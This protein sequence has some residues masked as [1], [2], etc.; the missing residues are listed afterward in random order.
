[1]SSLP[2]DKTYNP[3]AVE[4]KWAAHW[5]EHRLFQPR[6]TGKPESFCMVIP[7]PNV[8]GSLHIGHALNNTLQDILTRWKRMQGLQT[9]W[10]PGTD[11]AGI[12]TQNV[13]ERQL[14]EEGLSREDLGRE[15]F[16]ERVWAW[17]HQSGDTIIGQLKQ[18][19]ASC[20]WDRL[21]FTMDK[22][23]SLA[24]RKVF[25][26]LY[27]EGLIYRGERL[28][29]WCPRCL[30]ALSDIEVEHEDIKGT[31]YHIRYN[32]AEDPEAFLTVATTRPETL[33]GDTAVAV[34]PDD[35]RYQ[36]FI[37]KQIKLPLTTR[38]IPIVADPILVDREFGTGAVKITPAH[39]FNDFEA[40]ERHGLT[41]LTILDFKARM[42]A[43]GLQ[44][45]MVDQSLLA[46][47]S[48][49]SVQ[50][51]R[52][53]VIEAL[54]QQD[55]LLKEEDH[56]MALGKCYRCKTVVE[57]YLSPQWFVK[58]SPLAAP[59]ID[60]VE[61]GSIRIIPEGWK[62]NYLGWMRQIKDWCIS[63]QIWWGHQIPAWY[64]RT[65]NKDHL[66][67]PN[68][69]GEGT[70]DG[71]GMSPS[72]TINPSS[73]KRTRTNVLNVEGLIYSKIRTF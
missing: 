67:E 32:L 3:T 70:P 39:D 51:A 27:D 58:T 11:H 63:R 34:H 55:L 7:P 16:I 41:P 17:R 21:R 49:K 40:G 72:M 19:G 45:A 59:A 36:H 2:L 38:T 22:G 69:R 30:T 54:I 4:K 18:L 5:A 25:V 43:V 50:E 44:T 12:A 35:P 23:L 26:Q 57:P 56:P 60:A 71:R 9:L 68:S 42:D 73:Q 15:A 1:M 20:D 66:L 64:C 33:L 6:Q 31:L 65:C 13:V 24:V 52:P 47:L 14:K 29:N 28:I 8:T 62:N 53:I 37:G 48:L 61:T 46:T 10:I